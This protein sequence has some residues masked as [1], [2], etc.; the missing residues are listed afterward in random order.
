LFCLDHFFLLLDVL[1][2][3]TEPGLDQPVPILCIKFGE[4]L[5]LFQSLL[6]LFIVSL[7]VEIRIVLEKFLNFQE[8]FVPL[9]GCFGKESDRL[10]QSSQS[11]LDLSNWNVR[12]IY[13]FVELYFL[14]L[15]VVFVVVLNLLEMFLFLLLNSFFLFR[16][17]IQSLLFSLLENFFL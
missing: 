14:S 4:L 16:L 17:G 13:A 9:I 10:M 12:F 8:P 15:Y 1:R 11:L 3:A 7:H 2:V 6:E 5:L